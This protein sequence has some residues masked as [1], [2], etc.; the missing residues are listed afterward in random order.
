MDPVCKQ[1]N[2][3]NIVNFYIWFIDGGFDIEYSIGIPANAP[4]KEAFYLVSFY[5]SLYL[6]TLHTN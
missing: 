2:N 1:W 5:N 6:Y 4:Y 3:E